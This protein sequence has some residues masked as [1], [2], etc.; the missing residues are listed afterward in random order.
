MG[1]VPEKNLMIL[2][3]KGIPE[4]TF[5]KLLMEKVGTKGGE[6]IKPSMTLKSGA[7]TVDGDNYKQGDDKKKVV[8][9]Y[10]KM[11]SLKFGGEKNVVEMYH[12]FDV[13]GNGQVDTKEWV[14]RLMAL[15]D[16]DG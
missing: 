11:K 12:F 7:V 9:D 16:N 3:K 5:I 10:S 1:G 8:E 2:D 4:Y 13:D 6:V 14:Q 15:S